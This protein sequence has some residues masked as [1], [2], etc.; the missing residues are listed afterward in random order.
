MKLKKPGRKIK[1][2]WLYPR[3]WRE[4]YEI[5]FVALLEQCPLSWLD[6]FDIVGSAF[7]ERI[8][9]LALKE[10]FQ[11]PNSLTSSNNPILRQGLLF[12]VIFGVFMLVYNLVKNLV[13]LNDTGEFIVN[14]AV[15]V[16]ALLLLGL[17]G[18]RVAWQTGR[19]S[20]GALAGL[21][22]GFTGAIIGTITLFIITFFSIAR[23]RQNTFMLQDFAR[24]GMTDMNQFIYEDAAGGSIFLFV[25]ALILGAALGAIGGLIGKARTQSVSSQS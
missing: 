19:I 11:M 3:A 23:V 10:K 8:R 24:S 18:M 16:T 15:E 25:F 13:N 22:A 14:T 9:S 6:L 21:V 12:G 5:E 1:I 4:R 17:V 7:D 20:Q 2:L